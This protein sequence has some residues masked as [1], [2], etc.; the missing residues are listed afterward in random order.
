MLHFHTYAS[1]CESVPE[2][3]KERKKMPIRFS[4]KAAAA[5]S[6][7]SERTL[8]TAIQ[9]E[10]LKATRVGRRVLIA[11]SDL[12]DYLMGKTAKNREGVARA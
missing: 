6:G 8:H 5:E 1:L 3:K 12:E 7:L 2:N 10:D 9:K 4:I 11:P